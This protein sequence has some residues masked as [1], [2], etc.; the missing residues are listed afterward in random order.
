MSVDQQFNSVLQK[1]KEIYTFLTEGTPSPDDEIEAREQLLTSFNKLKT[2][3]PN[4]NLIGKIEKILEDLRNWDS[5]E[6]WFSETAL[7]T[8]IKEILG[9]PEEKK[10]EISE[11]STQ[12]T[13][14]VEDQKISEP[15][16][17]LTDIFNKV[18]D[19]FKGEIENL[20]GKIEDL[21]KELEK[22]DETL[23][24]K[25]EPKQVKKITPKKEVKLPPPKIRI[26]VIKKP[27]IPTPSKEPITTNRNIETEQKETK[28]K[29]TK[30]TK[31]EPVSPK[32][33]TPNKRLTPIPSTTTLDK[34]EKKAPELIP[35]P[36]EKVE[37]KTKET[38]KVEDRTVKPE[39]H[40]IVPIVTEEDSSTSESAK[41]A[42]EKKPKEEI[43]APIISSVQVEEIESEEIKSSGTDLFNVFSSVGEKEDSKKVEPKKK[44]ETK[45]SN[46]PPKMKEAQTREVE[47]PKPADFINFGS[48]SEEKDSTPSYTSGDELSDNKDTLYQE[49]I[50]LEGRRYSLEKNF[51]EL[52][53]LY[54]K[55]SIADSQYKS[56]SD[57]L[58]TK[59][60]EITSRIYKIRRIISSL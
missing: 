20:K 8:E 11:E 33:S 16:I 30:Q 2:I 6:L 21:K 47:A 12:N 36:R 58:K 57:N 3:N 42:K 44:V 41:K 31:L 59:L 37:S 55:G 15:E 38:Q 48:A 35:I 56:E 9:L 46:P 29:E 23:K 27:V 7:P 5:L 10:P 14:I 54:N 24:S 4:S 50:A 60:G 45:L 40:R 13:E 49:L 1:I 26:P 43:E 18:S 25:R 34:A 52:D 22:K 51:K 19:Q 32:I 53:A 39:K 28:Q 17:D